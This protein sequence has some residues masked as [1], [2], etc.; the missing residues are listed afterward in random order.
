MDMTRH[1]VET[2]LAGLVA[3][4]SD[5]E[6]I[7]DTA[8]AGVRCIKASA[9]NLKIPGVYNPCICIILQ[10]RKRVLLEGEVY[11]YAPS[12]FLAVSVD[13]PVVGQ[14]THA[15]ADA[16]YLCLQIDIDPREMGELMVQTGRNPAPS[17]DS[18]RG[19]F[20]GKVSD[21]LLESAY[22][23]L[24]LLDTPQDIPLLAPMMLREI[25]YRLL[26]DEHG[27]AIVQLA[28]A[29]SN[30]QRIAK[31]I[32]RIKADLVAPVRIEALA[33]M[34]NMS[35]SSFHHHFKQ[36]TAMSPLQYQKRLRL[37]AARQILMSEETDA[38]STA[39][40]VGYESPSQFSREYARLFGAPPMR[41]IETLRVGQTN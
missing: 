20:V 25:H 38:A 35:P 10:G 14:I 31:V 9:P 41:D 27:A 1:D 4:Y 39:Y 34:A 19:I 13:L 24:R 18:G 15:S 32:Q 11:A 30:M 37:T 33:E 8:I 36:V 22:R 6:G 17:S 26:H 21:A 3:K 23:L 40:R 28:V 2:A 7:C 12:E 16:P 29:N 5:H